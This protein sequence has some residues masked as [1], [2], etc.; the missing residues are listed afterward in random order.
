MSTPNKS[1]PHP[2]HERTPAQPQRDEHK[3]D[4]GQAKPGNTGGQDRHDD[5]RKA[6]SHK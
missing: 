4:A 5:E 3:K 6:P 1:A 2:S